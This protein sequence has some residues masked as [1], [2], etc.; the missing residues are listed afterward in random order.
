MKVCSRCGIEKKFEEF[1]K[2]KRAGDGYYSH[3]AECDNKRKRLSYLRPD[4]AENKKKYREENAAKNIEFAKEYREK[5]KVALREKRRLNVD[6]KREIDRAYSQKF[7]E[8]IS[9]KSARR[10]AY[11]LQA[12]PNW[13]SKK[14]IDI[15][16]L[17]A[18][19]ESERIGEPCHV[20]H[21]VPL[22]SKLVC[23]LHNE[24]NLQVLKGKDNL[25]KH[26]TWWPDM[27]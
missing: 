2:K 11:K 13:A 15:F 26:N 17:I 14:H 8:K 10:R 4:V 23:G 19:E 5:N 16:Y 25:E 12:T 21:I 6:H 1:H 20:D 7:P 24:F 9:A 18:K 3:C 27:P 22:K